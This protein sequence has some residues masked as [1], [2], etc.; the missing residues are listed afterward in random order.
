MLAVLIKYPEQE[1]D[2]KAAGQN[3]S[4][5]RETLAGGVWAKLATTRKLMVP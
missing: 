1:M 4:K 3:Q 2:F 5:V